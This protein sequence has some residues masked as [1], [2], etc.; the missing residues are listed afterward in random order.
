MPRVCDDADFCRGR[1][2]LSPPAI[3]L[4]RPRD[5]PLLITHRPSC[6]A[7]LLAVT[8]QEPECLST[9]AAKDATSAAD[10]YDSALTRPSAES[11]ESPASWSDKSREGQRVGLHIAR[12]DHPRLPS[13]AA[14]PAPSARNSCPSPARI[15][16]RSASNRAGILLQAQKAS[17]REEPEDVSI[18]VASPEHNTDIVDEREVG[19]NQQDG[20]HT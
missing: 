19:K 3:M 8:S 11:Q 5:L 15:A 17:H 18:D 7:L 2:A 6:Y 16:S 10:A 4:S 13:S 1:P 20:H 12:D 14:Q 9:G